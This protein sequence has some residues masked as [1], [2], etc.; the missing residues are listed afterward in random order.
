MM[1]LSVKWVVCQALV[2]SLWLL[3]AIMFVYVKKA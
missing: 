1:G 3:V 2:P